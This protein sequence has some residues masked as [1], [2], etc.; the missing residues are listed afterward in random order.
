MKLSE[1][2]DKLVALQNELTSDPEVY[3]AEDSEGNGFS[4]F[5]GDITTDCLVDPTDSVDIEI[6]F[7][8]DTEEYSTEDVEEMLAT[9]YVPAIVLWP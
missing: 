8:E 9:G 5:D 7:L 4:H 6:K 1:L 2:V 3:L